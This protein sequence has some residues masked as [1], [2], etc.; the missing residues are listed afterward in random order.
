MVWWLTLWRGFSWVVFHSHCQGCMGNLGVG[1]GAEGSV[2]NPRFSRQIH[3]WELHG[4]EA[5]FRRLQAQKLT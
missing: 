3:E 2:W 1:A 4:V 5:F